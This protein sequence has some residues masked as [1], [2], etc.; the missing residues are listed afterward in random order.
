M[1]WLLD[2]ISFRYFSEIPSAPKVLIYSEALEYGS[3]K[4]VNFEASDQE[5]LGKDTYPRSPCRQ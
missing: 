3:S 1:D 2:M 4:Q 5:G